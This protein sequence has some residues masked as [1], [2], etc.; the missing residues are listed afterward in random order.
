MIGWGLCLSSG[1]ACGGSR[2][3][4]GEGETNVTAA[5]AVKP[6]LSFLVS[7]AAAV[8]QSSVVTWSAIVPVCTQRLGTTPC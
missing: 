1:W 4:G 6:V 2:D 7:S 8:G 5:V 3:R